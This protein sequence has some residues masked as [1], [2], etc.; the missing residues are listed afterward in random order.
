[1]INTI[2]SLYEMMVKNKENFSHEEG[3]YS[4]VKIYAENYGYEND[5]NTY[6]SEWKG[7]HD[8]IMV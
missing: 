3:L 7:F 5:G 1:M 4:C 6:H 8:S 2:T